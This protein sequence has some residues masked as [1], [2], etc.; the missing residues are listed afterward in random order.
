MHTQVVQERMLISDQWQHGQQSIEVIDPGTNHVIATVPAATEA[1]AKAAIKAAKEGA[2]IARQMPIHER[3]AILKRTAEIVTRDRELFAQTIAKEGSKTI[4]EARSEVRRCIETLTLSGEEAKRLHGETIPF[5]QM[6]GHERRVGYFYRFPIGIIV[7]ITPFNDPLNLVAHK[8][9]PAIAA[10]NSLIIKPSSFTPLSALRLVKAL[11]EAGLP[12]KIVQVITGHGSVIGPTLTKHRDVRLI[13]FTGGYETGEKIARSAGV[14]KLAMELG[15]NSPTIVLQDAELMEAVASCVSG[16]FC[17][18]GQNCIGVQR[19]YV[20]QSVFNSFIQSFVAQTKQ[21]R[22]G[23]KQSEETDIG[24]MISEKEAKRIERWVE[25]A[26]EEGARVLT[27]GR[28]TGAYFEP[29]VLTNVSPSSRLA[30]E[31]AFAPI[32][33]IEGVHSL[34]EAVARANDVDFG[35]QAGLFTNN[36]TAA[37]SAIEKLEVGGIMVNDSSDVRIDAMP[38]GGIKKSGLG[39]EGVRYAIEEMT[40]QKVVAFHLPEH[41]I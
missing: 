20:E 41:K 10:G 22:L 8:I 30:K 3:A 19:I 24:P 29:T 34:T 37:F 13:S 6:P 16:A 17:A 40:E 27:G 5:S 11:E 33:I 18:A 23:D 7:A 36:L 14:K 21:L 28:R 9:G 32:V 12:K 39:R 26:K 35:L 31:E 25:E 2:E 38:F 15:S 4:R 1:D